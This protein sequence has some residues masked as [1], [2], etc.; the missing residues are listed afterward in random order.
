[1]EKHDLFPFTFDDYEDEDITET[2]LFLGVTWLESFGVFKQGKHVS[3]L[4]IRYDL[5]LMESLN[6]AGDVL[7]TQRFGA[8]AITQGSLAGVDLG[9]SD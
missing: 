5:A 6:E 9:G 1:M 3:E 2:M 7:K 8:V 4:R